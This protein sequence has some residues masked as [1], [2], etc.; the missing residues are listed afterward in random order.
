LQKFFFVTC[1]D[2]L[3][4]IQTDLNDFFRKHEGKMLAFS[5]YDFGNKGDE[6]QSQKKIR[7]C[8]RFYAFEQRELAGPIS[9][10][11]SR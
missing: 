8:T 9:H 6:Y 11:K 1:L 10:G 4:L 7:I 5:P 3:S 2:G